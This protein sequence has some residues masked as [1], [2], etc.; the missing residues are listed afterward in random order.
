MILLLSANLKSSN[1]LEGSF[2]IP[3]FEK[4]INVNVNVAYGIKTFFAENWQWLIGSV[5]GTGVLWTILKV[6]KM[7]N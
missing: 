7:T 4:E 3:L 1:S 5:L 6:L 2:D